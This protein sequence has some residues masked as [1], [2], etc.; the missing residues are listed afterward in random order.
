[1]NWLE[2]IKAKFWKSNKRQW[3][4]DF[5]QELFEILKSYI[6]KNNPENIYF[7]LI[8]IKRNF[9]QPPF[10]NVSQTFILGCSS[11]IAYLESKYNAPES[12][13]DKENIISMLESVFWSPNLTDWYIKDLIV[14]SEKADEE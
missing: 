12:D 8:E 2:K 14:Y 6:K 3:T 13:M 1:M 9:N 10:K 7:N 5:E 11:F 4:P